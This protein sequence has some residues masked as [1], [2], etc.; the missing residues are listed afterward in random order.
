MDNQQ[1]YNLLHYLTSQQYPDTFSTEQQ[2][3][4]Q[5]QAKNFNVHHNLL[6]KIDKKKP[7]NYIKLIRKEELSAILYMFH[8]DPTAAH[9]SKKKMIE[10][11]K[12]RYYWPQI[13]EDIREYVS[14][15]DIC[16]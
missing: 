2:L 8:N 3:Q 5:K 7:E 13:F 10:K 11:I 12:T 15:C 4:L 6:Y 16:Q 1:Y 14:F 9:A